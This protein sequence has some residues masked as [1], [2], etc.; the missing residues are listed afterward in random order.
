MIEVEVR[1]KLENFEKTFKKLNK[2]GNFVKE[3]DRFTLVYFREVPAKNKDDLRK[4][5]DND[6]IDLKLRVT[7]KKAELVLKHGFITGCE[8]RREILLPI[9][10]EK[11]NEAIDFL[12]YLGWDKGVIMATKTFVFDCKGIDFALVQTEGFDYFEAE[13][14]MQDEKE[15]EV[16]MDKIKETCKKICLKTFEKEEF[17]EFL[18]Q[19]NKRE[20]YL[21][22]FSNQSF[23]ELKDKFKEYF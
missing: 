15:A 21:F 6:P 4:V 9:Q 1:G 20:K 17:V 14:V 10:L 8:S 2:I 12:K 3:K 19:M 16:A 11:F 13:V 7:D 5:L 18:N 22:D 23:K